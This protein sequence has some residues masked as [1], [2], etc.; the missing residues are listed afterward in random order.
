MKNLVEKLV[1]LTQEV[2]AEFIEFTKRYAENKFKTSEVR[3]TWG[4]Q[5]WADYL[6]VQTERR[7]SKTFQDYKGED[8]SPRVYFYKGFYNSKESKRYFN[9]KETAR[10]ITQKGR[11]NFLASEVKKAESRYLAATEKLAIR[12]E[13]KG[14]DLDKLKVE[15]GRIGVNFEITISDH[16]YMVR[17]FTIIAS[18]AVQRPHYRYLIK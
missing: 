1:G 17:A 9:A 11:E 5:E 4:V 3:N 15:S 14:L 12:I 10:R 13:K 16:I 7:E 8:L 2:K 6:G 18:G